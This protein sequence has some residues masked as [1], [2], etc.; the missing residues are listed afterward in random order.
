MVDL[1]KDAHYILCYMAQNL[2]MHQVLDVAVFLKWFFILDLYIIMSLLKD[3]FKSY[4]ASVLY[5]L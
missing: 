1:S 2:H 5:I 4:N 3:L